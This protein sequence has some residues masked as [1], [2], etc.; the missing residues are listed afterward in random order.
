MSQF[1]QALKG[2][3]TAR[4]FSQMELAMEA[5]V[6]TRHLSFLETGRAQPS[7]EMI[8]RLSEALQLPLDAR[9]QLLTQAG[10]APRYAG[11]QW[12]SEDMA[13]V[14]AAIAHMLDNHMPYP[15]IALDRVWSVRQMNGAARRLYGHFGVGEGDSLL[16][17]MMS[18]SLPALVENWPD[19]AHHAA[20]RLRSE[21]L[22]QGGIEELDRAAAYLSGFERDM[23][24]ATGP[25][26]PLVFR[27]G[28]MRLAMFATISQFGTPEDVILE[29]L[30]I[31]L[32]FPLDEE[33]GAILRNLSDS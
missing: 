31:E 26:V 23:T 8:G 6:S 11:R 21:S 5:E 2:W 25:V 7:R 14:R 17:L 15:A 3:R 22:A 4:R 33:S 18:E 24:G 9:N 16:D 19:V 12:G 10:F 27:L 30:K 28:Q 13:P 20:V 32:Y 29:D 1:P